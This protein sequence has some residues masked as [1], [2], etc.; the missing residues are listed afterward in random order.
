M[1]PYSDIH[2]IDEDTKYVS[3]NKSK[4]VEKYTDLFASLQ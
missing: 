3:E 2:M 1:T 4:I